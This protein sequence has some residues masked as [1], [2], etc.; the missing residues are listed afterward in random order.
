[1]GTPPASGSLDQMRRIQVV[2]RRGGECARTEIFSRAGCIVVAVASESITGR[3][4][5]AIAWCWSVSPLLA[6][7]CETGVVLFF[8]AAQQLLFAQQCGLQPSGLGA[9][10]RMQDA[11]GSWSGLTNN[12]STTAKKMGAVLRMADI[13]H[14]GP[15]ASN[16]V[17][18]D[19]GW[20]TRF[21]IKGAA[22]HCLGRK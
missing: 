1:M 18:I 13:Y 8:E 16:A 14:T 10:E 7:G 20:K 6:S 3:E 12:A 22:S 11:A 2:A 17:L 5:N 21:H 19:R 15:G 4:T 9:F